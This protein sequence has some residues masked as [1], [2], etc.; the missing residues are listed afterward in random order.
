MVFFVDFDGLFII[1]IYSLTDVKILKSF[2]FGM[3]TL[4]PQSSEMNTKQ[5][6]CST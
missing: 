3:V 4:F 6:I 5:F 1:D 2:D